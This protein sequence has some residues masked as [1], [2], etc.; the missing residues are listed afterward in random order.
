MECR[1]CRH[2]GS[3]PNS[4]HCSCKHPIAIQIIS[5]HDSLFEMMKQIT[6]ESRLSYTGSLNLKLNEEYREYALSN[7]YV[8]FPINFDPRWIKNCEGFEEVSE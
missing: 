2:V 3:V 8:I 7:G 4:V 1:K 5:N 6:S